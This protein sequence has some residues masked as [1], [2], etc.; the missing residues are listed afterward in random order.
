MI[1]ATQINDLTGPYHFVGHTRV[2]TS[3]T[4]SHIPRSSIAEHIHCTVIERLREKGKSYPCY[5]EKH[6][7]ERKRF[8]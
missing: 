7:H 4:L 3:L 2:D 6:F 5:K 8:F 1:S